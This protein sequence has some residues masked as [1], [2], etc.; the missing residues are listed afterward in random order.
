MI[1]G[2]NGMEIQSRR[3]IVT[4]RL[5]RIDV[6]ADGIPRVCGVPVANIVGLLESGCSEGDVLSVYGRAD[7]GLT[8]GDIRAAAG[9]AEGDELRGVQ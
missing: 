5:P 7:N 3:R 2:M 9:F 4:T 1:L 6:G 8:L